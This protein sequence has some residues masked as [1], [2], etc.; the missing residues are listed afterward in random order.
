[1]DVVKYTGVGRGGGGGGDDIRCS[2]KWRGGAVRRVVM[3]EG[4]VR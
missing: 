4:E 1:M 2:T 3:A